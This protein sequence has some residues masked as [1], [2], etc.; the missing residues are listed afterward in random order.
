MFAFFSKAAK[1]SNFDIHVTLQTVYFDSIMPRL[2]L[3]HPASLE[4]WCKRQGGWYQG[5]EN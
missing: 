3:D 1:K 2:E 5:M 4:A